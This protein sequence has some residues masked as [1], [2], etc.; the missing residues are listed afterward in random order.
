MAPVVCRRGILAVHISALRK[1]LGNRDGGPPYIE[2]VSR[3][4]YRFIAEVTRLEVDRARSSRKQRSIAV[5]PARPFPSETLSGRDRSTG[6]TIADV[7]IDRLGRYAQLIVRPTRA[8]RAYADSPDDPA[9]IGRLLRVDAVIDTHFLGFADRVRVSVHLIRSADGVNLWSGNFDEPASEIIVLAD[10]VTECVLAHLGSEA[11]PGEPA[12]FLRRDT[13]RPAAHAEVYELL[14]RGRSHLL[15]SSI[16]ELPKAI[17]AF[18]AAVELDPGYAPAHAG[19]AMACCAQASFRMIPP[20]QAYQEAR[21]AALRAL[22]MDASCADAQVAL[23]AVLFFSEWNWAGTERSLKRA[24]R[25][26]PNHS[27]AYLLYGQLLEA[28]GSSMKASRRN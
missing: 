9:T 21:A 12:E 14:G 24:L 13:L 5:L 25:L 1:A 10:I 28:L 8:I 27:E 15:S 6:L 23:G 20:A 18:R 7:L 19:L 2:T 3:A 26:N 11:P 22:A 16:F 4:G 17:Q